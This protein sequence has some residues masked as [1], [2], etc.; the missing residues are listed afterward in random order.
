MKIL[1][2]EQALALEAFCECFD[3]T[4]SGVWAGIAEAMADDWGI[5]NPEAAI[6][7]ARRVLRGET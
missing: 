1:T 5:D 6:E 2:D 3:T 7:D 4:T